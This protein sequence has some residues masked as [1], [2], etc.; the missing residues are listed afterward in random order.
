MT[1]GTLSAKVLQVSSYGP[2]HPGGLEKA[3]E[4]IFQEV[5]KRNVA[6]RWLLSDV[7]TLPAAED[8]IRIKVWNYLDRKLG[9]PVPVPGPAAYAR[10][11]REMRNC[12]LVHIHDGYYLICLAAVLFAKILRRRV[13]ITVHIWEVP[14]QNPL[15]QMLQKLALTFIVSPCVLMADRRVTYNREILK[16]LAAWKVGPCYIPNGVDPYFGSGRVDAP[17]SEL[18]TRSGLPPDRKI[19][20]F[21]GRFSHKK[22]LPIVREIAARLPEVLFVLCGT[23]PE[24]P[25]SWNLPNVLDFG[26]VNAEK[27]KGVFSCADLFLLPSRGEGFPLAIQEAMACGLACAVFEET[28]SALGDARELFVILDDHAV[29][30]E[31]VRTFLA[32]EDH[33]ELSQKIALYA[34]TA[35]SLDAMGDA[36]LQVYREALAAK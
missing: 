30:S 34:K 33:A 35:W 3:A 26:W 28:W 29:S 11:Y 31:G 36:Y 19:V 1:H 17:A 23:G 14:Y 9:L 27:L 16:K 25:G 2:P 10:L 13:V 21:A 24:S 5:R 6:I 15:L 12:D 20:V 32:R 8:T 18:R 4:R 22:G 7:P